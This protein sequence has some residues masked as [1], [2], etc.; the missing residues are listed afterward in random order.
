[1]KNKKILA[2]IGI[3]IFLCVPSV[4][5]V[6]VIGETIEVDDLTSDSVKIFWST[7]E[8]PEE[9]YVLYG[10]NENEMEKVDSY[11][12]SSSPITYYVQLS[13]LGSGEKYYFRVVA[14]GEGGELHQSALH[15]FTTLLN[16]PEYV[17]L[18]EI[19]YN[20][21]EFGWNSVT[22]SQSYGVFLDD[23][24]VANT[25]GNSYNFDN[26]DSDS[27]YT[28]YVVSFNEEGQP[29]EPS[30]KLEFKTEK[31]PVV[32]S[33][34]NVF[35]IYE[36]SA[37]VEWTTDRAVD[38]VIRYGK[39]T[40]TDN[41]I[42][43]EIS[44]TSH[45]IKLEDL[46]PGTRYFYKIYA[47]GEESESDSFWTLSEEEDS[48]ITN[49]QVSDIGPQEATISWKTSESVESQIE[50]GKTE[51]LSELKE[52]TTEKKTEHELELEGLEPE[53][54]Y[55]YRINANGLQSNIK[56]FTTSSV[57]DTNGDTN[58]IDGIDISDVT[59]VDIHTDKATI[60]WKTNSFVKSDILY[61]KNQD[62]LDGKVEG[63]TSK[64]EHSSDIHG[65]LSDKKYYFRIYADGEKSPIE[66]FTTSKSEA[67][68]LELDSLPELT[69]KEK[70][71]VS[72]H[73]AVNSRLY[74]IVNDESHAQV[75]RESIDGTNFNFPVT[76][77]SGVSYDGVDGKNKITVRAWDADGNRDELTDYVV[78]DPFP[79]SLNVESLP[80]LI[81]KETITVEGSS[82]EGARLEFLVNN[83]TR[84]TIQELD[85]E[86]FS[87]E[88]RLGSSGDYRVEVI[89]EDEAG[90]KAEFSSKV[91]V[92]TEP[93]TAEFDNEWGE[94]H[95][96]VYRV[97]GETTPNSEISIVNWGIFRGCDD[98]A[99]SMDFVDCDDFLSHQRSRFQVDPLATAL[100]VER[101]TTADSDGEF[102]IDVPLMRD[103]D[104]L[105]AERHVNRL[106]INITNRAGKVKT[107]SRN[108]DFV[109]GCDD[110]KV[111]H[112]ESFPFNIYTRDLTSGDVEASA[113]FPINYIGPGEPE[114]LNVY[115][116]ED[117]ADLTGLPA[118]EILDAMPGFLGDDEIE[119][120][121]K[122]M[123]FGSAQATQ[124]DPGEGAINVYAPITIHEYSGSIDNLPDTLRGY[125]AVEITY[126]GPEGG[127][128]CHVYPRVAFDLH[129]PEDVTKWLSPEQIN[130]TIEF[131]NET[132]QY[133]EDA[134]EVA[135]LSS[136]TFL[137]LCGLAVV[138]QYISGFFSGDDEDE[139]D[140]SME[141][142]YYICDRVLCPSAPPDCDR[143]EP[144]RSFEMVDD[145]GATQRINETQYRDQLGHNAQWR[146]TYDEY[147]N[148]GG[149][150]NWEGFSKMD[151]EDAG[152]H[153]EN[154]GIDIDADNIPQNNYRYLDVPE[155]RTSVSER[156]LFRGTETRD[157]Y[158]Q[159]VDVDEYGNI[160]EGAPYESLRYEDGRQVDI[161]VRL[162]NELETEADNCRGGTLVI[163]RT[164]GEVGQADPG[165]PV[166]GV[167]QE[168]YSVHCRPESRDEL[169]HD[170]VY[171]QD[172]QL[173]T[174]VL[175]GCYDESCPQ[176]DGTK[177]P[178][179][180]S[181]SDMGEGGTKGHADINPAEGLW[182]SLKCVC[183]PAITQH[184]ENYIKIMRGAKKCLQQ[185]KIGEVRGGFCERLL[186]QFICD[187]LIE[188]LKF[189]FHIGDRSADAGTDDSSAR[190]AI[191]DYRDHHEQVSDQL[192]DRYGGM[193]EERFG[194]SS[195]QLVHQACVIGISQDWSMLDSIFENYVDSFEVE[196]VAKVSGESR[197]Y[198]FNPFTGTMSINYNIY[199]GLVAGGDTDVSL[200]LECDRDSPGYEYC[201]EVGAEPVD[202]SN[203]LRDTRLDVNSQPLNQNVVY[204]DRNARYWYNQVVLHLDYTVGD[205]RKS[206]TLEQDIWRKGDLA[207]RCTFKIPYGIQC[208]GYEGFG[209]RDGTVWLTPFSGEPTRLTPGYTMRGYTPQ[210]PVSAFVKVNSQFRGNAY[211]RFDFGDDTSSIE[212]PI[213]SQQTGGSTH[214]TGQSREGGEY[215][216][217]YLSTVGEGEATGRKT[218]D[219]SR[220]VLDQQQT[221]LPLKI[222]KSGE[223]NVRFDEII[224]IDINFHCEIIDENG[225]KTENI[226]SLSLEN[227]DGGHGINCLE[228]AEVN[229]NDINNV[230][231][232]K[233]EITEASQRAGRFGEVRLVEGRPRV[234]V[235]DENNRH[236]VFNLPTRDDDEPVDTRSN[237]VEMNVLEDNSGD[238]R[239]DTII[240]GEDGQ[241]QSSS[242]DYKM[243]LGDTEEYPTIDFL[244]PVQDTFPE[245]RDI[246]I[247][248]NVWTSSN[249]I[250]EIRV[251][252]DGV[253]HQISDMY[254]EYVIDD[255]GLNEHHSENECIFNGRMGRLGES[256]VRTNEA[257]PF[258]EILLEW[259][260]D[261]P[262]YDKYIESNEQ[263][264]VRIDI[265]DKHGKRA[266]ADRRFYVTRTDIDGRQLTTS[267]YMIWVGGREGDLTDCDRKCVSYRFTQGEPQEHIDDTPGVGEWDHPD[268][269]QEETGASPSP[270]QQGQNPGF[271]SNW[272]EQASTAGDT[273]QV[274]DADLFGP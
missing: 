61:G 190:G 193:A 140:E 161:Y 94:T 44:K 68:F 93:P 238:G 228:G 71:N 95:F 1:M 201:G 99:I 269:Q 54:L 222:P 112:I 22:D 63:T 266:E 65:L 240:P 121:N 142:V 38:S 175:S 86:Y 171:A 187:L 115:V 29:S 181:F 104:N 100:G 15:D 184:L 136:Y 107:Y 242:T 32:I 48:H 263:Y 92:D 55:Y 127:G 9:T 137:G 20:S 173:D 199:V 85:E 12:W 26:L 257:P 235:Q 64:K 160:Q 27:D 116:T 151:H 272:D 124:Y 79:P 152:D 149:T 21:A 75:R 241:D 159:F 133:T 163:G 261:D 271:P 203:R 110:W 274:T 195:E 164:T 119:S 236:I 208:S 153:F 243:A 185:A 126:E 102:Q 113:F 259:K 239:G 10:T 233:M 256:L 162:Q 57:D 230:R 47:D 45:E 40:S 19:T 167:K 11:L 247:G 155:F 35:D 141:W 39:T 139:C 41:E 42:K 14:E 60:S 114:V 53:T 81:A 206:K 202:I 87:E 262:D 78:Y 103:Q 135:R 255:T 90:N 217:L 229:A 72:G 106:E 101:T 220:I 198:G 204:L 56:E 62:D 37:K 4:F 8:T 244:Q 248:F 73:S 109:P 13:G 6:H 5:S 227:A 83:E 138:Y 223:T 125:M 213:Q 76:L 253:G 214:V 189:I 273:P 117:N 147:R 166:E 158:L 77:S 131:L 246:P 211:L 180:F 84:S 245:D 34:I 98:A 16:P 177:C 89:A 237:I 215:Y 251:R 146:K 188:A 25:S 67:E 194:L 122:Y 234:L 69:N 70:V 46:E 148:Q 30:D 154:E 219:G 192:S 118:D 108:V 221:T 111:G 264:R 212:Y 143:F 170:S 267:D 49:I 254:C 231:I 58:D 168:G 50:Y 179:W 97:S 169:L 2:I 59:V 210:N 17:S 249:E 225:G 209:A 91:E 156:G 132:I 182:S 144:T 52:G 33:S 36:Y 43:K 226:V 218:D 196:P 129:K 197:P 23:N 178:R 51:S 252:V 205:E 176:F 145:D 3:M 123:T 216:N 74:I 172:G 88:I 200:W 207:G 268:E 82:E 224:N 7:T 105:N 270:P 250:E 134:A 96:K 265:E 258:F 165:L 18:Q 120:G 174:S 66:S 80:S 260:E 24:N 130:K 191:S 31:E 128:S 157:S 150:K 183:L 28:A 186:A 232:T